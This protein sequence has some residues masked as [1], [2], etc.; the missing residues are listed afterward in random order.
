[1]SVVAPSEEERQELLGAHPELE[2]LDGI[3]CAVELIIYIHSIRYGPSSAF[4]SSIPFGLQ[5]AMNTFYRDLA[6]IHSNKIAPTLAG[7]DYTQECVKLLE[8]LN[9]A[10]NGYLVRE[11]PG[12]RFELRGTEEK[13][14]EEN[15]GTMPLPERAIK[16]DCAISTDENKVFIAMFRIVKATPRKTKRVV[17]V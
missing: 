16:L 9:S 7:T 17:N 5:C 15:P 13:A 12:S 1:M 8:K 6:R 14:D 4:T 3:P 10:I 2:L 11:A